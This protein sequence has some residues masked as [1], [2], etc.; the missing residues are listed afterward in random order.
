MEEKDISRLPAISTM[1]KA[2]VIDEIT[3]FCEETPPPGMTVLMLKQYVKEKR[4]AFGVNNKPIQLK[5]LTE[6]K[7]EELVWMCY[8]HGIDVLE[9]ATR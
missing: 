7:K 4:E 3:N 8:E 1:K 9:T 2:Q 5:R 6:K